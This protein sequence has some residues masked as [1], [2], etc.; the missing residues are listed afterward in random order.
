MYGTED[1]STIN[2]AETQSQIRE[3]PWAEFAPIYPEVKVS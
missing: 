1:G 2:I 3:E